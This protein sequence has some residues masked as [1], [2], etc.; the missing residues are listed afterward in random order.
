MLNQATNTILNWLYIFCKSHGCEDEEEYALSKSLLLAY[1]HNHVFKAMTN[2]NN[3]PEDQLETILNF[4]FNHV[5]VHEEHFVFYP[6][7][8]VFHFDEATNSSHE[9]TNN[10]I[11]SHS[12]AVLPSMDVATSTQN[13]QFQTDI[14]MR[15]MDR[16]CCKNTVNVSLHSTLPTAN[17]VNPLLV[18]IF[19]QQWDMRNEYHVKRNLPM[20][21]EWLVVRKDDHSNSNRYHDIPYEQN[22]YNVYIPRFRRVRR[23]KMDVD[24]QMECSCCLFSRFGYGCIHILSVILFENPSYGGYA[25]SD[26]CV[27]WWND[28]RFYAERGEK[29]DSLYMHLLDNDI[30]GP[31]MPTSWNCD[32]FAAMS[33]EMDGSLFLFKPATERLRNY[34]SGQAKRAL[35]I[36][37]EN[38]QQRPDGS[39]DCITGPV[40]ET[41]ASNSW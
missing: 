9:G 34:T 23:V 26:V 40:G 30:T 22:P 4:L 35:K 1:V 25:Q 15:E 7:K 31:R 21:Y 24:G 11:K 33:N 5:F 38:V 32:G 13:L 41:N 19:E 29:Y 2:G 3:K 20:E 37:S 14:A 17:K 36:F 12:A 10:G 8:R 6:R 16:E 27:F 18:S 39:K 28:Y